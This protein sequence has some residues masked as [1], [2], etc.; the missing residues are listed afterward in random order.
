M[1]YIPGRFPDRVLH[2]VGL[3]SGVGG[4]GVRLVD[5]DAA[6]VLGY[7]KATLKGLFND[8]RAT[9]LLGTN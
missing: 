1:G 7:H 4:S 9:M 5:E 8:K 6:G 2:Y 3:F